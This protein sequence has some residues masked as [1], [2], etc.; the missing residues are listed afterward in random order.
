M[1]KSYLSA[2]QALRT[3]LTHLPTT[4]LLAFASLLMIVSPAAGGVLGAQ[5]AA[6]EAGF[7]VSVDRANPGAG[8]AVANY[9][10]SGAGALDLGGAVEEELSRLRL[11][12][13][14]F[15]P[16]TAPKSLDLKWTVSPPTEYGFSRSRAGI[17][18]RFALVEGAG[19]RWT[20][21]PGPGPA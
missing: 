13:L 17:Q 12:P 11:A 3:L 7:D 1:K 2:R 9:G 4:G 5:P 6:L 16:G 21:S 19:E 8:G 20:L 15:V 14:S 18:W 10:N